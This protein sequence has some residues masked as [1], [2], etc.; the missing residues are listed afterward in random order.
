MSIQINVQGFVDGML[1]QMQDKNDVLKQSA[2]KAVTVEF[3]NMV[4]SAIEK[5]TSAIAKLNGT[6]GNEQA[7]KY[8]ESRLAYYMS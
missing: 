1:Q 7:I 8:H 3:D 5:H 6:A 4:E 2:I